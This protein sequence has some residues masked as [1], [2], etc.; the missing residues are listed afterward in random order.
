MKE[1]KPI[2]IVNPSGF[3]ITIQQ[4]DE[5][6]Y[7]CDL[8]SLEDGSPIPVAVTRDFFL[9]F[10]TTSGTVFVDPDFQFAQDQYGDIIP[11]FL[12]CK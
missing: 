11:V 12:Y 5:G 2:T 1:K 3:P 4:D 6:E 9:W 8:P 10:T 7:Y